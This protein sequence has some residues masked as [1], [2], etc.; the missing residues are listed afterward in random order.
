MLRPKVPLS[1]DVLIEQKEAIIREKVKDVRQLEKEVKELGTKKAALNNLITDAFADKSKEIDGRLLEVERIEKA[2][3][4]GRRDLEKA[5]AVI[6]IDKKKFS[7]RCSVDN[8]KIDDERIANKNEKE[9]LDVLRTELSDISKRI[10]KE[11]ISLRE[12][13]GKNAE[14][15]DVLKLFEEKLNK[16][17]NNLKT[18]ESVLAER[19]KKL[20]SRKASLDEKENKIAIGDADLLK[21]ATV[22]MKR[23]ERQNEVDVELNQIKKDITK[24]KDD[25][26]VALDNTID[27]RRKNE[28]E[29]ARL[30]EWEKD[31]RNQEDK[32]NKK[33]KL[34]KNKVGG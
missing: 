12:R 15:R 20:D 4:D 16:K 28:A 21:K 33:A 24:I 3:K 14:D 29:R 17:E 26:R 25:N 22:L 30:K 10:D 31:L 6:N 2:T 19:T 13:I 1:D 18:V 5:V 27:N 34:L 23:E 7:H 8:K 11:D 9:K 32:L